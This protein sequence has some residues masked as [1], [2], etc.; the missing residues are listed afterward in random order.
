M[1]YNKYKDLRR[2]CARRWRDGEFGGLS[3]DGIEIVG[4]LNEVETE[5]AS[6]RPTT[7]R[8]VQRCLAKGTVDQG[9][10]NLRREAGDVLYSPC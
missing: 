4:V 1:A 7:A 2:Q 5:V 9:S 6:R 3:I 10:E 8:G